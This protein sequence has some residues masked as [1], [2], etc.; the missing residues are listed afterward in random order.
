MYAP[1]YGGGNITW[2]EIVGDNSRD[3]TSS[4]YRTVTTQT[5]GPKVGNWI[6]VGY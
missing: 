4:T 3:I 2:A 5:V 6:A 1:N